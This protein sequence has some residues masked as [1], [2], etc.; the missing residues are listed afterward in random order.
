MRIS[1]LA[2]PVL[3]SSFLVCAHADAADESASAGT[4]GYYQWPAIHK[5]VIVFTAEGDLWR[6]GIRGGAAQR[7][8]SHP[9]EE[10]R[11]A[12]S[13]DGR[14]LAFSAEYE[15][16]TE[17]YAMPLEGGPPIRRTYEGASAAV[18]GWTP[19]GKVIYSTMHYSTLPNRQ[20]A[21]VDL[22]ANVST[23]LPLNQSSDGTFDSAGKVLYFT[24]CPFQGSNTKRYQGGTAQ[25]LWKFELGSSEA[26]PL[27]A[28]FPGTSKNPMFWKNRIYFVTDRDG[29]MNIWSMDLKGGDL[30]QHTF[31]KGWDI[32]EASL[33]DGL[34]AY[35]S[36]ADIWL[37]DIA[38]KTDAVIPITLTS[39]FDQDREKWVKKPADYLTS[40]HLS[41]DGDRLVLT[42]RGKVF[43]APVEQGRFVDATREDQVRYRDARFMPDGK[44]LLALSDQTG[45]LEF[46]R[47][48]AN[49]VGSPEPLTHDGKVFRFEGISS[50]DGKMVAYS[51]KNQ[52]LW[53][54]DVEQKRNS[55]IATNHVDGFRDLR[56][57]P[58]SQWLAYVSAADNDYVQISLYHLKDGTTTVLTSDRVNSLSPAW[59]AD[60]EWLY[61]LSDRHLESVVPSPWGPREPEPYFYEPIKLYVVS[62]LK[63][64]R[65]PFEANDE[66]YLAEK[67]KTDAEKPEAKE[68]SE[69]KDKDTETKSAESNKPPAV[70]ID[71]AGLQNRV[72]AVPVPPGNYSSLELTA[73]RL[74]WVSQTI[75]AAAKTNVMSLEITNNDPKPKVFAE[76]VHQFELSED[77]KKI[78]LSKGDDFFVVDSSKD[79]PVKLEKSVDLKGWTFS[80]NPR[81][82]RRQMFVEAWRLLR[83]FFYDTNMQGVDWPA[84]RAKYLPL[85]DRVRDRDELGYLIADMVGELS[86]LHIFVF[87]GEMREGPDQ[88][89]PASLGAAWTRDE[90]QGGYRIEHIY[91]SDPDFPE[92]LSPLAKPELNITNG[93]IIQA[94]NGVPVLSVASPA[95]LLR[96]QDGRQTLLSVKPAAAPKARDVIVTPISMSRDADL[97]YSDWE[98]SRRMQVEELGKGDIGYVHL[99]AMG[100]RDIAAWASDFYPV[101]N[102][103]GLIIDVRH[104]GGGNIDSWILEKLM[105]KAWFYWQ[106]RVGNPTWNMQYAFRGR[107]VVLCD[108]HT[109]S[110]GEAFTEGFR[111]L[112][113]GKVIG[114]RTWG[115]EIWLS[116]DT[117]LV[118]HGI[119]SAAEEGV[120]GPEGKWLIEG[121]GVDPDL[122]V[123][124]LPHSTFQGEDAQLKAAIRDLQEQIRLNPVTVPPHP[125]YPNKAFK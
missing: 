115:G 36:G 55:S 13:P 121:H 73:K 6:V 74:F 41:P 56:W 125:P 80:L 104:N 72:S 18:A 70:V 106:P 46:A 14:T 123:D 20:L 101:F 90:A 94:I 43:V 107:A 122:V 16:P 30:R 82:E 84:M 49:G 37:L 32:K 50:P 71:L 38:K 35:Q 39:D 116:F 48:P 54:F 75:G 87:G 8:T 77:G 112:G 44:S 111:R 26:V 99:R 81:E 69:K 76:D 5:D 66:L 62:L 92:R 34:I 12:I 15:G 33:W 103:K 109:G 3:I 96:N 89:Q 117:W 57:S 105:R 4:S 65:S 93:D 124:N 110:D 67:A 78:L 79:A 24:R 91:V 58:D 88:V 114:T 98:Y 120:Y 9:G 83:D 21:V 68:K 102:R 45:E 52:R 1:C 63:D 40:A 42:A 108:E 118:D 100:S 29:T 64:G 27:T 113:L 97:R 31:H 85:V 23:V 25:N 19:D 51:D 28:D 59:S 60:G 53:L 2:F 10:F 17:V 47:L 11:A 119:A 95:A 7:L 22:N 86:A 61:F